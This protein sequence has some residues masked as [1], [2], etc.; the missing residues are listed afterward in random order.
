M[1][2]VDNNLLDALR[3]LSPADRR[4][5]EKVLDGKARATASMPLQAVIALVE[6]I[7]AEPQ[8]REMLGDDPYDY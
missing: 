7:D 3:L 1:V 6:K 5:L 4:A 8:G 2:V